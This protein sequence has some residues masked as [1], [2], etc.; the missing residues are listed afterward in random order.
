MTLI[1][2]LRTSSKIKNHNKTIG[3]EN[4]SVKVT[5]D[6]KCE[7]CDKTFKK[8]NG[9]SIHNGRVHKEDKEIKDPTVKRKRSDI[10]SSEHIAAKKMNLKLI[11]EGVAECGNCGGEFTYVKSFKWHMKNCNRRKKEFQ[12]LRDATPA[13]KAE[14]KR[15]YDKIIS[16]SWKC[17]KIIEAQD[18]SFHNVEPEH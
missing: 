16:K 11:P 4:V 7:A 3:K 14:M 17:E 12:E 10:V 9:L 18:F 13:D 6:F 8:K 1:K 2:V 5:E 15:I